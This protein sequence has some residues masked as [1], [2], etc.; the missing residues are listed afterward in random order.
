MDRKNIFIILKRSLKSIKKGIYI[1]IKPEFTKK[2]ETGEKNYE[3][4]KYYP[5]QKIDILYVYETT[6]TCTLKYIIE[7]GEIIKYPNLITKDGYGNEEFNKGLKKSK[8]AYEIRHVYILENQISLF[9][10]R[11]IY[12]FTPPQ[13]F[14]YDNR[15][16]ELTMKLNNA[17]R[18]LI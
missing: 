8:Y 14:A 6:P 3:F 1:S 10:L 4:R 2:I 12:H 18:Q 5:N 17:K 7:L 16:P 9:E 13:S 11:Q 15:Y